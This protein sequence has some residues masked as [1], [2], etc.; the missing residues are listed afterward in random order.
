M[1]IPLNP[2]LSFQNEHLCSFSLKPLQDGIEYRIHLSQFLGA[3]TICRGLDS[4]SRFLA[5]KEMGWWPTLST[6]AQPPASTS[7][8]DF[9]V[10]YPSRV[11]CERVGQFSG[12]NR[13]GPGGAGSRGPVSTPPVPRTQSDT[14]MR[15]PPSPWFETRNQVYQGRGIHYSLRDDPRK[16]CSDSLPGMGTEGFASP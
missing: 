3:W 15:V 12:G 10:P 5:G 7:A 1:S 16:R 2:V 8:G 14:S 6:K 13:H 11:V 9:L 4:T